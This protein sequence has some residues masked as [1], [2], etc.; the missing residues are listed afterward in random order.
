MF[1]KILSAIFRQHNIGNWW[2]AFKNVAAGASMY[3]TFIN[4]CL[5]IP[6]AY[7][8]W[9]APWMFEKGVNLPFII[10]LGVILLAIAIVFAFE[11]KVSIPSAYS[12]WNEQWWKHSNPIRNKMADMDKRLEKIEKALES[13]AKRQKDVT[14]HEA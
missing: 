14:E 5:L 13:I 6:T 7:A 1:K 11:Y 2:G 8:T 3:V 10:F 9:F 12:F 4:L